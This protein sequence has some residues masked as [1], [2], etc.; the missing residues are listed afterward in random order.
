MVKRTDPM[1]TALL[2]GMLNHPLDEIVI[3]IRKDYP[4]LAEAKA[5][6][7]LNRLQKLRNIA[8]EQKELLLKLKQTEN[9]HRFLAL[10]C[11][12]HTIDPHEF[13]KRS[14]NTGLKKPTKI[15][16]KPDLY[17]TSM[18]CLGMYSTSNLVMTRP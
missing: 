18:E 8:S 4:Q 7:H 3:K 17:G 9:I 2:R 5:T 14:H 16:K 13:G 6:W 12:A 1:S 11:S 10:A 15:I